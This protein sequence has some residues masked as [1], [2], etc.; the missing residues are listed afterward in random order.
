MKYSEIILIIIAI[1]LVVVV[2]EL[3]AIITSSKADTNLIAGSNRE[4][5]AS[6]GKLETIMIGVGEDLETVVNKFCGGRKKK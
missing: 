3:G 1:L 5:T 2:V 6:N 4:L